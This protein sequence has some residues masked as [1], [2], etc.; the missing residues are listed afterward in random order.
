MSSCENWARLLPYYDMTSSAD[1]VLH[2]A[3]EDLYGE[4]H[5]EL[6][7]QYSGRLKSYNANISIKPGSLALKL[8]ERLIQDMMS[9]LENG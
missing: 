4:I 3:Y 8:T 5:H 2:Q 9:D 1:T 6:F 7:I